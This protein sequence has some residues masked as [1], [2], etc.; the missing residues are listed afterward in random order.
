MTQE[1]ALDILKTGGNIFL[2]GEP[3]SGKTYVLNRYVAWLESSG[4]AVAV[5]ASTGIAATHIGGMTIHS[6]SGIGTLERLSPYDLDRITTKERIV[7]RMQRTKVLVID[8]ISMLDGT[9]LDMVDTVCRT[10]MHTDEAFGG[11]QV[12]LVGDF[13][14]LPPISSSR[15][16]SHF[17]FESEAWARAQFLTC[18]L[19]EQHRHEDA[20]LSSL[21]SAIR[22]NSIGDEHYELLAE[23]QDIG[24]DNVEP[25]RLY[26]HNKDVDAVNH[27]ELQLLRTKSAS[28]K[29]TSRGK[30]PLVEALV[31]NCL[32]P[33]VL[34]L[35]EGAMV[36]CTRN[37]FEK[38]YVNG[39]LGRIVGFDRDTGF[40]T[41]ETVDKR[42]MTI[43]PAS[44]SIEEDG[45]VLAEV[46]QVPLRLAWAITIH[47]S[48]GMSLD[49]AVID[50]RNAFTYGQGYVALSRVRTLRGMKLLGLNSQALVVDPRI[51]HRDAQFRTH[52]DDADATFDAMD[53]EEILAMQK[54]FVRAEGG[55]WNETG[56][57][58][59]KAGERLK[60]ESTYEA[61]RELLTKGLS[62]KAI[63]KERKMALSTIWSHVE[64]LA[65]DGTLTR[66]EVAALIPEDGSWDA[67][68]A[69]LEKAYDAHGIE[70]LKPI[71]EA[72]GEKYDYD[73]IR[74]GR[75]L[76]SLR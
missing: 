27:A 74:L 52:S 55:R 67:V 47:K 33:E 62:V 5:T 24:Y 48:Q 10:A 42:I 31:R 38:G 46:N 29:M 51:L 20:T 26:T 37:N 66:A 69:V 9:T 1:R 61:T 17:A 58:Q 43:E 22:E 63:A 68:Y 3:G 13:F 15:E 25:T 34:E 8:E 11:L 12:I 60:K 21:L 28:Y 45:K 59:R 49:A 4:I 19:S 53:K 75:I 65:G 44:W 7:K 2:T 23:Q 30:K 54:N 18:Y 16:A 50:L 14:Q 35:K 73:T 39:T 40:P 70:K 32:S 71:F 41:I 56:A 6:W 64:K 72:T 57:P 36:M 76:Y